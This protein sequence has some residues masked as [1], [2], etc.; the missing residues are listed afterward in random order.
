MQKKI[1]KIY[2]IK[3]IYGFHEG[4]SSINKKEIADIELNRNWHFMWSKFYY[5][6]KNYNKLYALKKTIKHFLSAFVK[7]F[8][9]NNNN[10][11]KDI[12]RERLSG[13]V[14]SF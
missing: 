3:N 11:K 10:E 9:Q 12:Y 14:N 1:Q 8:L 2:L 13:L 5:Y 7:F 4:G 6:E